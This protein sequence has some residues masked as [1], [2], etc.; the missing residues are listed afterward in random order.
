MNARNVQEELR[1]HR[2]MAKLSEY[3]IEGKRDP[4]EVSEVL[5]KL[6]MIKDDPNF[7][8]KLGGEVGKLLTSKGEGQYPL[9]I[10]YTRTLKEMIVS[11]N[12]GHINP[13]IT[14]DN[15]PVKGDGK[16]EVVAELMHLNRVVK[17]DEAIAEFKKRGLRPA[18]IEVLL[19]LGEKYP[20]IQRE[21]PIVALASVWQ[22]GDGDRCVPSL[23]HDSVRWILDLYWF[24]GVWRRRSR[25][26]GVRDPA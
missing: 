3:V 15:F 26:L 19:A 1:F 12:Y 7:A 23:W 6:Q 25:F 18:K 17:S 5:E 22:D 14:A 10:N 11:G 24:G 13:D 8:K 16:V 4:K 2:L 21:F 20:D 9:T